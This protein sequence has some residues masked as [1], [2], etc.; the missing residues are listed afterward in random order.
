MIW[1]LVLARPNT[2]LCGRGLVS[3]RARK[4]AMLGREGPMQ[5]ARQAQEELERV[6]CADRVNSWVECALGGV[7]AVVTRPARVSPDVGPS[8]TGGFR[9]SGSTRVGG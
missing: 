7:R 1:G 4:L 2:S 9:T 6:R 5:Q 8:V 3:L